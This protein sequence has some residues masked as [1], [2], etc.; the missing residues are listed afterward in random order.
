MSI[1]DCHSAGLVTST[2]R[3]A[4]VSAQDHRGYVAGGVTSEV[5]QQRSHLSRAV[6][7]STWVSPGFRP[8]RKR[9]RSGSGHTSRVAERCSRKATCRKDDEAI[10]ARQRWYSVDQTVR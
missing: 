9:R 7:S 5:T 1:C 3:V 8:A 4:I 2:T 6:C 10:R